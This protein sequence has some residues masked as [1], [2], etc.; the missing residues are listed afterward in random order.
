MIKPN[1]TRQKVARLLNLDQRFRDDNR[2]LIL[3]LW[4][5]DGLIL[6]K[7]QRSIYMGLP[8][9]DVIMRRR[10]EFNQS[11]PASPAILEK[12]FKHYKE[13]RDEFSHQGFLQR[14]LRRIV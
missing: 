14:L 6:S 13:F 1:S 8:S 9:P 2:F 4:E 3:K 10:R 5:Q 12:R 11:F 7:E